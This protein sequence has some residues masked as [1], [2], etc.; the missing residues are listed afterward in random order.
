MIGIPDRF[1]PN[2]A[3]I[4][5]SGSLLKTK[6]YLEY[7]YEKY[8]PSLKFYFVVFLALYKQYGSLTIVFDGFK[9]LDVKCYSSA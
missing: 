3:I 5:E 1:R 8:L 2:S 4:E 7:L 9:C 6:H